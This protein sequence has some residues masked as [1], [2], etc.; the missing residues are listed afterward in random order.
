MSDAL[1]KPDAIIEAF[2]ISNT[3]GTL[4]VN[5]QPLAPNSLLP[6]LL[7]ANIEYWLV[8]SATGPDTV[9]AW[10]YNS[11]GDTGVDAY[12]EDLGDWIVRNN[13][14]NGAFSITGAPVPEPSTVFLVGSGLLGLLELRKRFKK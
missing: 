14:Q 4:G 12:R 11:T 9:A 10:Q 1:G 6:P 5:N 3:M 2:H 13:L 8:A 7:S